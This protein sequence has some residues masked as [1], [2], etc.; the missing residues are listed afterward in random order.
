[1]TP[2]D[3]ALRFR[4]AVLRRE[5]AAATAL[6]RA[7]GASLRSL[8]REAE[9]LAAEIAAMGEPPTK[10]QLRRM[11]RFRALLE[12]ATEEMGRL[13]PFTDQTIRT[14][15]L[16]AIELALDGTRRLVQAQLPFHD[17]MSARLLVNW[18]RLPSEAFESLVGVLADGTPLNRLLAKMGTETATGVAQTLLDG[19]ALGRN[20]RAVAR[21]MTEQFGVGLTRALTISRTE[22]LRAHR[23][24][25]LSAFR[26][27][28]TEAGGVVVGYRRIAALDARTCPA[29]LM[30]H[31]RLYSLDEKPDNHPNCRCAM[32]AELSLPG[33]TLP[34]VAAEGDGLRWFEQQGAVAQRRILGG[35]MYEAWQAGKV[36]P[37]QFWRADTHPEWGTSLV[38]ASLKSVLGDGAT[39]FYGG[40]H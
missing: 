18:N 31:G 1:M 34:P 27:N 40:R 2:I 6:V 21:A 38:A 25:T 39:E 37:D 15:Q 11:A 7:W 3:A 36:S 35:P 29:C 19:L 8:Q 30:N 23:I 14:S 20:P 10:E 32:V 28:S 26:A 22:T 16:D 17:A 13:I 5:A 12:Q 24:A 9:Q 4:A 33:V